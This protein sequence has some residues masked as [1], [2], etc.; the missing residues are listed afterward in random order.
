MSLRDTRENE[1]DR[2]PANFSRT[3]AAIFRTDFAYDADFKTP[4]LRNLRNLWIALLAFLGGLCVL[5][6]LCAAFF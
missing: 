4:N 3:T 6:A 5:C 2:T 1:N